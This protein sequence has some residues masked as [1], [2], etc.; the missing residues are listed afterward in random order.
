MPQ[1]R[2]EVAEGLRPAEATITVR[3]HAGKPEHF[4]LD[5]GMVSGA[6]DRA[7]ISVF[8]VVRSDD[9]R[10]VSVQ[11]PVEADSGTWRIWVRAEDLVQ[12]A[13]PFAA[14]LATLKAGVD[15]LGEADRDDLF[16]LLEA[17]RN[18]R[19]PEEVASIVRAMGEILDQTPVSVRRMPLEVEEDPKKFPALTARTE[20]V[21]ARVKRHREA[22]GM[23]QAELA[24]NPRY[25]CSTSARSKTPSTTPATRRCANWRRPC[26]S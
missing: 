12:D 20:S 16:D 15:G 26:G 4:P 18:S 9:G 7:T 25:P 22:A 1:L 3:D 5:R 17:W 14:A 6:G 13:R 8:P 19:D 21:A 11:L 23:T 2:C 24:G 10:L